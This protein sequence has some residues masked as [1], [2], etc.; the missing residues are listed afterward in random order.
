MIM[1]CTFRSTDMSGNVKTFEVKK[2]TV[3]HAWSWAGTMNTD[4]DTAKLELLECE[5]IEEETE[6][7]EWLFDDAAAAKRFMNK[8]EKVEGVTE[9]ARTHPDMVMVFYAP[10]LDMERKL[11]TLAGRKPL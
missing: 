2:D 4:D 11:T 1:L 5:P 10:S 3:A 9:A 8:A 6:H 7:K